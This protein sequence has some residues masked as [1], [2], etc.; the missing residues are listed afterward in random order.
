LEGL[1]HSETRPHTA[2]LDVSHGIEEQNLTNLRL[3]HIMSLHHKADY[4]LAGQQQVESRWE[5]IR[6]GIQSLQTSKKRIE[7]P[8]K[9]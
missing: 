3:A 5:K 7:I 4:P 1:H 8:L 6:L 9:V 2:S